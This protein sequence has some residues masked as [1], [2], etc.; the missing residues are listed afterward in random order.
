MTVGKR[1]RVFLIKKSPKI[2]EASICN[3]EVKIELDPLLYISI[4][5]DN[6]V[7]LLNGAH[8]SF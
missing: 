8:G 1:E 2:H 5:W 6:G 3:E 4:S 7:T